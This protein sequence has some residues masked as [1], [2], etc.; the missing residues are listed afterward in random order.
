MPSGY[1]H[2]AGPTHIVVS[3]ELVEV[4][5]RPG[6]GGF[7]GNHGIAQGMHFFCAMRKKLCDMEGP[8]A[9]QLERLEEPDSSCSVVFN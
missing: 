3:E 5:S 6:L 7:A 4:F 2:R 8:V 9:N 1:C